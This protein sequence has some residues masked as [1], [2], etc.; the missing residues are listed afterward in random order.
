ML[1]IILKYSFKVIVPNLYFSI[2]VK[3]KNDRNFKYK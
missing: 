3:Q 2:E 1:I